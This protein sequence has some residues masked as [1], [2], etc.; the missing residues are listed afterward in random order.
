MIIK[1]LKLIIKFILGYRIKTIKKKRVYKVKEICDLLKI[2]IPKKYIKIKNRY[3]TKTFLFNKLE[4]KDALIACIKRKHKKYFTEDYY[5]D[6]DNKAELFIEIYTEQYENKNKS[7][8]YDVIQLFVEYLYVFAPLKYTPRDYF[9][10][11]FFRKTTKEADKFITFVY[12]NR[13]LEYSCNLR[14]YG[15]FFNNKV[16]FN[17]TFSKFVKRDW[18]YTG[19]STSQ[20]FEDFA[21]K[22]SVFIGKPIKESLG[23]KDISIFR[24]NENDIINKLFSEC[25]KEDLIVEEIV[26][27]NESIKAFNDTTLNTVRIYSL[28]SKDNI[29][30]IITALFRVGRKNNFVDNFSQDGLAA[31]IDVNT[32]KIISNAVDFTHTFYEKH[33]DSQIPFKGFQIPFW[34]KV[35]KTVKEAAMLVPKIRSI[36]WDIVIRE[37]NTIEILE[38]NQ[39]AGFKAVQTA[40]QVGKKDL[41]K[42]HIGELY[43]RRKKIDAKRKRRK[44]NEEENA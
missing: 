22:H 3:V 34:D 40:D 39:D 18:L 41:Y 37:D 19:T 30:L 38:G 4:N 6:I 42:I 29:P 32:G 36:G 25:Y 44:E 17:K 15:K 9:N 12:R 5:I 16:I 23:G 28:L 2:D 8:D 24:Y 35:I 31:V 43:K 33:P 7:L 13:V 20:E 21:K 11:E 14:S 10:F 26:S 27:N 1:K